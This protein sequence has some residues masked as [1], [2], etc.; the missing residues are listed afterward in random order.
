MIST[1]TRYVSVVN[2]ERIGNLKM[3]Q[4]NNFRCIKC[5]RIISLSP[6]KLD[7]N[8]NLVPSNLDSK[9]HLCLNLDVIEES[10]SI[11]IDRV[12]D[13]LFLQM[14][15]A[16]GYLEQAATLMYT[17]PVYSP[18]PVFTLHLSD[19]QDEKIKR[20]LAALINDRKALDKVMR[21][22]IGKLFECENERQYN[23]SI[24]KLLQWEIVA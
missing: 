10:D 4:M 17:I 23:L 7:V 21:A 14:I 22:S 6:N 11:T 19:I 20:E 9:P 18:T 8:G 1:H 12:S 5:Y 13:E 3:G 15:R 2:V 16:G 24:R